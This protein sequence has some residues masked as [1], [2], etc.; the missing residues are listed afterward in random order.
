MAPV[1]YFFFD[2][3]VVFDQKFDQGIKFVDQCS[4]STI[5]RLT[6]KRWLVHLDFYCQIWTLGIV[7]YPASTLAI[8]ANFNCHKSTRIPIGQL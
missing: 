6:F 7:F 8:L 5:I 4:D 1:I 2:L 3:D